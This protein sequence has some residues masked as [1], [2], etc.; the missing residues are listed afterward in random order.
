M[1]SLQSNRGS[2]LIVAL[3]FAAI[4]AIS[5]TS[6]LKLSL[7]AG[8]LANR[9]F[10]MNAAQNLVDAGFERTIW[11]LNDAKANP[12]PANWVDRAG[13]TQISSTEYRGTFP[14]DQPYYILSGNVKGQ[15]KVWALY[16]TTTKVWHAVAKAIVTLGD[17]TTLDKT[18]ECYLQQRSY[19]DGG[20][21]SKHGMSFNGNVR[22]DSW[23]SRPS[24]TLD[25]PYTTAVA[26][27]NAQ[28]AS[29]ALIAAANADIYGY[30]AI[31]TD[32]IT[33]TG[34]T[35]GASGRVADLT[36][37]GSTYNN[38]ID[39]ARVTFDFNGSFPEVDLPSSSGTVLS[40][41]T[42]SQTFSSNGTYTAPSMTLAGA[43]DALRVTSNS[44]V[45]VI[46]TGNVTMSGSSQI[47]V[48]PGSKLTIYAGGD[49]QMTGSS[50]ILNG[51]SSVPNNP[52]CFTLLGTRTDAQINAGSLMQN[53][54]L[55]GGSSLSCTVYAPNA[56]VD[57]DGNADVY[58]SL[59]GNTVDMVGTGNFHQDESLRA[60]RTSG[61]WGLMKWR[62]L[63]T[64][65]QRAV[66]ASQL[67]F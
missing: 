39:P 42:T 32:T 55:R 29:P 28:I 18:A 53:W 36:K 60:N 5:L 58:G 22:I 14:T 59:V 26:L 34:L 3:M 43:A 63:S 46:F 50:G 49:F 57:V 11:A 10:Y 62:E 25:V 27:S 15:V 45:T 20:M 41:I 37:Q 52:D 6:Y 33:S 67:A 40:A 54:I 61:L 31:G 23:I 16:D 66:Y 17:G 24:A 38:Y 9:G 4:I 51:T 21:I 7:S 30:V 2:V 8:T 35:V 48:D 47:I 1:R 19:S 64:A 12:A 44:T 65:S 56:N 13:F